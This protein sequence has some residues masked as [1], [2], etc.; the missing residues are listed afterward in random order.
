MRIEEELKMKDFKSPMQKMALNLFFTSYWLM[1]RTSKPLKKF[2][3]SEPQ[4]NVLRILRGQK[5][6]PINLNEIQHRMINRM[7]NVTRLV[8]KLRLKNLVERTICPDNRR[9][10]EIVITEAGVELLQIIEPQ[11][12]ENYNY[13]KGKLGDEEAIALSNLL[14][15]LRT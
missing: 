4:Y 2:G 1:D 6:Q 15:K 10:V 3:L 13:L 8:E 9:K 5:Q 12:A 14:D 11:I 7:S